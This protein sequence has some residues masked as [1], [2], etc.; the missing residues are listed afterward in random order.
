MSRQARSPFLC[1]DG[2]SGLEL[3]SYV[4][5]LYLPVLVHLKSENNNSYLKKNK[6]T[7]ARCWLWQGFGSTGFVDSSP[8][9]ATQSLCDPGQVSSVLGPVSP[10]VG[11]ETFQQYLF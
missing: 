3:T 5:L 1:E 4:T 7:D 2:N 9:S 6:V 11:P 8:D 10:N